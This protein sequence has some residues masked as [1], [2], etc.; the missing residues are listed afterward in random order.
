MAQPTDELRRDWGLVADMNADGIVSV[1]DVWLWIKSAFFYPG[2]VVVFVF[3]NL[4][5][6]SR[7]FFEITNQSFGGWFSAL[8]SVAAWLLLFK[9]V[10]LL[11]RARPRARPLAPYPQVRREPN[12]K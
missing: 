9:L 4:S 5:E 11:A 12:M 6:Y 1:S 8:F 10:S 7:Q 3:G 2:D